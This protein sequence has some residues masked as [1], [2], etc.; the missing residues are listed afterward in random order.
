[1]KK[2]Y[3]LNALVGGEGKARKLLLERIKQ[4]G[5]EEMFGEIYIP[6][7]KIVDTKNG[8]KK[9]IIKKI[10]PGYILVEMDLTEETWHLIASVQGIGSFVGPK[11][12]PVPLTETEVLQIKEDSEDRKNTL[13]PRIYYRVGEKVRIVDGPF[14]SFSGVV[15]NVMAEKSKLRVMVSIFG[16]QTP[17]EL[18]YYQ[19]EKED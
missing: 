6:S 10:F 13:K 9:E 17:V 15:D 2:W 7:E 4:A 5:M 1:M 16:R 14:A 12:R 8:K 11:G 19:V 18:D 3:V